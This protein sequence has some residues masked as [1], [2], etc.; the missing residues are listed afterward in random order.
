M[1]NKFDYIIIA[2]FVYK[3]YNQKDEKIS[4]REA[5]YLYST[6]NLERINILKMSEPS[7]VS[8]EKVAL[9]NRPKSLYRN[10]QMA[11]KI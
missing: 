11:I 9:K 7:Q 8:V 6:S 2:N 3:R 4:H 5:E 10:F 1:I